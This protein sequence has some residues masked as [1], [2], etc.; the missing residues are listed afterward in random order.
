MTCST[1]FPKLLRDFTVYSKITQPFLLF[2]QELKL[3]II[4]SSTHDI[5]ELTM[6]PYTGWSLEVA[7]DPLAKPSFIQWNVEL[8]NITGEGW[9]IHVHV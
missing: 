3:R 8:R 2:I 1:F 4:K 6:V 5:V 9:D 7:R